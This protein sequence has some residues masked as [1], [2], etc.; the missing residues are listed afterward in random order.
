MRNGGIVQARRNGTWM[1]Y[2]LAP[3]TNDLESCLLD[4]F[5]KCFM[6]HPTTQADVQR[7]SKAACTADAAEEKA[8]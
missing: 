5:G 7:L 4:C 2:Q 8:R 3:A 6:N 1:Y